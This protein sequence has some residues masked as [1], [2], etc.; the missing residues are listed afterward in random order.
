ML[1]EYL[2]INDTYR[3]MVERYAPPNVQVEIND[4]DNSTCWIV[5]YS[6]PGEN[7]DCAKVLCR[8]NEYVIANFTPMVLT[9]ESAAYFNKKL[10]PYINE[11][12]RKL[13]KLLYLKSA[14]YNGVK[15]VDNIRDLESKDLGEI[16][17]LLFTDAEFVKSVKTKVNDKTWQYTKKE[18][19]SALES[20]AEDT[21][22]NA[23][24]GKESV[25]SLSKNFL[26]VKNYRNDVMHAHN[27]D[28]RTF[29]DAK[30][31]FTEINQQLDKEIGLIIRKAEENP[32]ETTDSGFNDT[33]SKALVAQNM[34]GA[35]AQASDAIV[36]LTG[37]RPDVM[38]YVLRHMQEYYSYSTEHSQLE[39]ALKSIRALYPEAEHSEII[40]TLRRFAS[41]KEVPEH[42]LRIKQIREA[43][44][45]EEKTETKREDNA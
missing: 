13:R 1:Q 42:E 8:V 35:I 17:E 16:F 38:R 22:W 41:H 23:L 39:T 43:A 5:T 26:I 2:F 11:F 28:V 4:I 24:L 19:I 29:R 7:E 36:E 34:S 37:G 12:E 30:K 21:I 31:L 15:K 9:N 44:N 40:E 45:G 14:I 10:F 20:I 33:L 6:L 32:D 27:I 25:T 18:I 3:A